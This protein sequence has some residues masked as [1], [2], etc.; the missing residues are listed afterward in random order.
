MRQSILAAA[1]LTAAAVSATGPVMAQDA[2]ID[3][4]GAYAGLFGAR[5]NSDIGIVD[6]DGV[7]GVGQFVDFSAEGSEVGGL[8]GYNFQRG[9]LIYGVE[10]SLANGGA[11][12]NLVTD[13]INL[14][15]TLEWQVKS[16]ATL[17][18]RVGTIVGQ[19]LFFGSAGVARSKVH[20]GFL[21]L[22]DDLVTVEADN[23]IDSTFNGYVLGVG[24]EHALSA[25]LIFR[26]EVLHT[27]FSS[28]TLDLL[29]GLVPIEY[30]PSNTAV[31]IGLVMSF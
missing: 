19:T 4:S 12:G 25:R 11:A 8:V 29:P 21:N 5:N 30:S 3:W 26:T 24:L 2:G 10:L 16:S 22:A 18:A 20:Y 31:R 17:T 1:A 23:R 14:D 9:N 27:E 6:L 28:Q 13:T 15:E 7:G